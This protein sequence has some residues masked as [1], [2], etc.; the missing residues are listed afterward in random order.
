MNNRLPETS[1]LSR[2]DY[3]AEA[4]V[5]VGEEVVGHVHLLMAPTV[6]KARSGYHPYLVSPISMC[7]QLGGPK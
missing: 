3:E 4:G 1:K 2:L 6:C 5:G 7:L